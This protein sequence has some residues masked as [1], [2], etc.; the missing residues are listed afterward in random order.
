MRVMKEG[1]LDDYDVR[2]MRNRDGSF[3]KRV[4]VS[5]DLR[6]GHSKASAQRAAKKGRDAFTAD[7]WAK[8]VRKA[9]T[10]TLYFS[11]DVDE[12]GRSIPDGIRHPEGTNYNAVSVKMRQIIKVED[13]DPALK[14]KEKNAFRYDTAEYDRENHHWE[15][16]DIEEWT[17]I[18]KITLAE[19][20]TIMVVRAFY[21]PEEFIEYHNDK[22]KMDICYFCAKEVAK[23][24]NYVEDIPDFITGK[25]I[26]D[27]ASISG[28]TPIH[29]EDEILKQEPFT[30]AADLEAAIEKAKNFTKDEIKADTEARKI[31]K[32]KSKERRE[33]K[34]ELKQRNQ[35]AVDAKQK[36]Y[37]VLKLKSLGITDE[38]YDLYRDKRSYFGDYM[39]VMAGWDF[40]NVDHD[41]EEAWLA[42]VLREHKA[43]W[44]ELWDDPEAN[45]KVHVIE[46]LVDSLQDLKDKYP[47]M[48]TTKAK[49]Q[50]RIAKLRHSK[51]PKDHAFA[52][53][54]AKAMPREWLV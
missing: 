25:L 24:L 28:L 2:S 1:F 50:E 4:S 15:R 43:K 30:V 45:E 46:E 41:A 17:A 21:D 16:L 52:D 23:K 3:A 7:D 19:L 9:F 11:G 37:V 48:F 33:F 26:E 54:L 12:N 39:Y 31:A 38:I 36:R 29:S 34:Y 5:K 6:D 42:G 53:T 20:A 22:E 27:Y 49:A 14:F 51:D 40:F 18:D 32:E 13:S 10:D 8:D 35:A 47:A 44:G